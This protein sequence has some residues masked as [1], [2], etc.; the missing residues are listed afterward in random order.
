MKL[1][2][3]KEYNPQS[4]DIDFEVYSTSKTIKH[5]RLLDVFYGFVD[6]PYSSDDY[7]SAVVCNQYPDDV[8]IEKEF[9]D[10]NQAINWVNQQIQREINKFKKQLS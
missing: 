10:K 9:T 6:A 1:I 3:K 5:D 2:L 7:F 4:K 8:W